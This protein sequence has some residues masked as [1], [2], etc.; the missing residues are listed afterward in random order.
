VTSNR[1]GLVLD[2]QGC[3]DIR[4]G[5]RGIGRAATELAMALQ[6]RP[7][8]VRALVLNPQL[9]VPGH[10][11]AELLESPLLR[12]NT[13]DALELAR[14]QGHV[15]YHLMSPFELATPGPIAIPEHALREDIAL[16]ATLYD[17]IPLMDPARLL[18]GDTGRR[19]RQRLQLLRSCDR[20][21][22]LS[23]HTRD[24]ALRLLGGDASRYVVVGGGA[25]S[26]FRPARPDDDP[27]GLLRHALPALR[28]EPILM[29][30][31]G[32][33]RKNTERLISAFA[34]L[35]DGLRR[36]HQLV[37]V[38]ELDPGI[39]RA[40]AEHGAA[41]G[42][43]ADELV[44]TGFVTDEVLLALYQR[45]ALV[46]VPSLYE[47]FGL[48]VAEAIAC[49]RPVVTSSTTSLPELL[50]LPESTFDPWDVNDMSRVIGRALAEP[51][52]RER[53]V[54]AGRRMAPTHSWE[55]VADRVVGALE[56]LPQAAPRP[57]SAVRRVR[58]LRLALVG[59]M[60]P[61]QSGVADYNGRLCQEL[62]E[63][64]D[65]DVLVARENQRPQHRPDRAVRARQLPAE[66]LGRTLNPASYDAILYTFGNS[67]HHLTA[68]D[69]ALRFPGILWL[70]DVRLGGFHRSYA[71]A[72]VL[73]G[74]REGWM[75]Q[76]L[77]AA[78][79]PRLPRLSDVPTVFDRPWQ[80][81]HGVFL[82]RT[83]VRSARAVIVHSGFAERM[84]RLDQ[85]PDGVLP[86]VF[87]IP[88]AVPDPPPAG[89]PEADDDL[90]IVASFGLVDW[91]KAPDRLIEAIAA[92]RDRSAV[93]LVFV[94]PFWE[95]HRVELDQLA[96]ALGVGEW[97]DFTG[98]VDEQDWWR[99]LR[100]ATV[101]AQLR[102]L[103]NA[104][105]SAAITHAQA[106]TT[107]VITNIVDADN[108]Y[109]RDAILAIDP[110]LLPGELEAALLTLLTD[111][112]ARDRHRRAQLAYARSCSFT[113]VVDRLLG[114]IET[115]R[116]I[117]S[118]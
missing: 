107:P 69:L 98:A 52:F 111:T 36:R 40:W 86:P 5:D 115:V 51:A 87:R 72:R 104:E 88:L 22:C 105:T 23:R 95:P 17:L 25:S 83:L 84:L 74:D 89:R 85:G 30:S 57:R 29:I 12:W 80:H 37:V 9:R 60:P 1:Y 3:Q 56:G 31:G 13:A 78:Y 41:A 101:T 90:P 26:R 114:D 71:E 100:R 68:N 6:S 55:A 64:V 108:E 24:D 20:V 2:L 42:F 118:A 73:P 11:P 34:G 16:L 44:L 4:N 109:P 46:V 94:G 49:G 33:E 45:A 43:G 117:A 67:Q 91:I 93:R 79:G 62:G 82:T 112:D 35:P 32:D 70:H 54:L 21:L 103:T 38:C 61:V 10:L 15:A 53:L 47:G 63:R 58:R 110:R 81:R 18:R 28:R 27:V 50:E 99:W 75:R 66:A 76:A 7:G 116:N 96:R 113:A 59:P 102:R 65:L 106:V 19:Y 8:L 97:V 14:R 77:Q 92:I 39:G 48:P